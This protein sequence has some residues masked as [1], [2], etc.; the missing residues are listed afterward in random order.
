MKAIMTELKLKYNESNK[1]E[2]KQ[3]DL[4][5]ERS[6]GNNINYTSSEIPRNIC[7]VENSGRQI[8]FNYS[9]LSNGL[10]DEDGRKITLEFST[11]R[12]TLNGVKLDSLFNELLEQKVKILYC[13][14]NRYNSINAENIFSVNELII[15]RKEN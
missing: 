10:L 9:F 5:K 8:F 3:N 15:E 2:A 6:V 1:G 14:S 4:I 7:F 11:H 13:T 12:V